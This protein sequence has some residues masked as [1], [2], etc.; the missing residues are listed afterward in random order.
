[1]IGE[2]FILSSRIK[3]RISMEF[4][5][6][7]D[8]ILDLGC[9][10]NPRYHDAMKGKI[11]CLDIYK[12]EKAQLVADA[13]RMPFKPNSFDKVISVNSFYYLRNPFDVAK[14]LSKILKKN[15]KLLLVT[16][17]FYPLHDMPH[18]KYRFSEHGIKTVFEERFAIKSIEP[19]G[20]IFSLPSVILHSAIKGFP[21]LFSGFLRSTANV[22]AYLIFYLPYILSQFLEVLNVFDKTK[23][24]PVYY[25]AVM[26]RR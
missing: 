25:V 19:V 16:P 10:T 24:V 22:L 12:N 26:S 2:F 4:D 8:Y 17:F 18:D 15:G 7:K 3:K 1:M 23:R 5:N 21:L 14:D 13:N 11:V 20:G 6:E 9:G